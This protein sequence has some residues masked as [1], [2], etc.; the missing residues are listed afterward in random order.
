MP[1]L[2]IINTAKEFANTKI[3]TPFFTTY[4]LIWFFRNWE[5]VY[6]LIY[7]DEKLNLDNRLECIQQYFNEN[8]FVDGVLY[9]IG[10]TFLVLFLSYLL[11]NLSRVITLFSEIKLKPL[12]SNLLD[13]DTVIPRNR[14]N[15]VESQRDQAFDT[16]KELRTSLANIES[17]LTDNKEIIR[18]KEDEING[19]KEYYSQ[20]EENRNSLNKDKD[21]LSVMSNAKD[22]LLNLFKINTQSHIRL[23]IEHL[24]DNNVTNFYSFYKEYFEKG[25]LIPSNELYQKFELM[26]IENGIAKFTDL[27]RVLYFHYLTSIQ[28]K[29]ML[30]KPTDYLEKYYKYKEEE[31]IKKHEMKHPSKN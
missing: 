12:I 11:L 14:F 30:H 20:L 9:N 5:L 17:V 1:I 23:I 3:K 31:F 4:T 24:G 21:D 15:I 7:F 28:K 13:K 25:K 8:P 18:N 16:I 26:T 22:D 6:S 10:W 27:G 19:H 29:T 2:S